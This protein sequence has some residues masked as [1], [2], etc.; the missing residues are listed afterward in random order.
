MEYTSCVTGGVGHSTRVEDVLAG[1]GELGRRMR[2]IDWSR[3]PLGAVEDWPQSLITC[4][5]I[6][7]TAQQP[8]FVWWGAELINLYNDAYV[9]ILGGKH[10]EALAR[11]AAEVWPEIWDDIGPRAAKAMHENQG[12]FDEALLLVME[13]NGYREETYFTFSYSPVPG[14]R[15]GPGGILCANSND[16]QRI[17]GERQQALLAEV[18]TCAADA[19]TLDEACERAARALVTNPRDLPFAMIYAAIGGGHGARLVATSG[20][21]RDHPLVPERVP[22]AIE[23]PWPILDVLRTG[24]ARSVPLLGQHGLPSGVWQD[25][26]SEA[27][28]MPIFTS[29]RSV[30]AVLVIG[31]NPYRLLDDDYRRFLE[32]LAAQIGL[33]LTRARAHDEERRRAEW[34]TELDRAKTA[35]FSNVSH[36]FRTPLTLMLGPTEDALRSGSALDGDL[37]ATVY[38]NELRLLRLVN[39]LLDF[40]RL[41]AGRLQATY[42]ATDLKTLTLDLAASFR[43]A[44]ERSGLDYVVSC[45]ELGESAYVDPRLYETIVLNLIGNAFKFTFEGTIRVTLTREAGSAVLRV[46]DTGIGIAAE[47]LP[48]VFERFHRIETARART[49]EGSGIGLAM[50]QELVRIHGGSIRVESEPGRGTTFCVALPLG[51]EHLPGDRVERATEDSNPAMASAAFLEE[52]SRWAPDPPEHDAEDAT[53]GAMVLVVDDNADMRAYL[54]RVLAPH[55]K[56]VLATDGLQALHLARDR[57]P[58]L[59]V[60][61]VMMPN[62]DGFELIESLRRD[63][64]TRDIPVILLSARAGEDPTIEGLELGA[65]DYLVKP[66]S[67]RELVARV[68]LH[69]DLSLSRRRAEHERSRLF[70]LLE[71]LPALVAVWSGPDH[72]LEFCNEQLASLMR[73]RDPLGRPLV[74]VL[75]GLDAQAEVCARVLRT[76]TAE[77]S[78]FS[79][80]A[81]FDGRGPTTRCFDTVWSPLR[82][83]A[84]DIEGVITIGFDVTDSVEARKRAEEAEDRLRAAIAAAEI[85]TYSW[86]ITTKLVVHDAG[87]Q[88]LFDLPEGIRTPLDAYAA[89]L[90]PEDR[91]SWT[92]AIEQTA[93]EGVA[94]DVDYR[95]ITGSDTRWVHDRGTVRLTSHGARVVSGAVVDITERRSTAERLGQALEAAERASRAKDE[96]MAM[97]GHELRNPL[98]P[99]RTAIDLIRMRGDDSKELSIIERQIGH[100][101]QLID[102]LLDIAR[103]TRGKV[104]LRR[105]IVDVADVVGRAVEMCSTLVEQRLQQLRVDAPPGVL[106][107][108]GDPVRLSQIVA[109]LLTNAAKYTQRRGAIAVSALRSGSDVVIRVEDNGSGIDPALLP[110]VFELFVQGKRSSDRGQ[111]GLGIGLALVHNLVRLHGGTVTAFSAGI[112]CGST[113]DVRLPVAERPVELPPVAQTSASTGL[114]ILLV[115]DNPDAAML[116]GSALERAGHHVVTANDGPRALVAVERFTPD[117]A[118]LDIGLPVMDGYELVARLKERPALVRCMFIAITGYGQPSDH[119]RSQRAGFH[120]H[121][122]KPVGIQTLLAVLDRVP[123]HAG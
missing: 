49:H 119:E 115:D 106:F 117:V 92:H 54:R 104:E 76:G 87:V 68:R 17:F 107:V 2:S 60:S 4:V 67:A 112:G 70:A 111:G 86:D 46:A 82:T 63:P 1:G 53:H 38:R 45:E 61:D 15:G 58:D 118:V 90:H 7:L 100:L 62:L 94:F 113:F 36:E 88:R 85:G 116:L 6:V 52:A 25:A 71:Q 37:L 5:R 9:T 44:I 65:D 55:W 14:D 51:T 22:D 122:V 43:S 21:E 56:V 3:T 26:P 101:V 123:R 39:A 77:T 108:D 73:R 27:I 98:A 69:L 89:R 114:K 50:V 97:L 12:T 83:T 23:T 30:A 40:S 78:R 75:R 35:F 16:T 120:H 81:P 18:S 10:P 19:Q 34:L 93:R 29:D 96:F 13:R 91:A 28:G 64:Q 57:A 95:V 105:D 102:D 33:A 80:T 11:P 31:R 24:E 99:I 66:F 103:V 79:V 84:G 48:R 59:V 110:H 8:M 41:E 20:I 47:H 121:L 32:L 42:R 74:D 72:L 109:N